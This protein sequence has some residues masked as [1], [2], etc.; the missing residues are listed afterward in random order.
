MVWNPKMKRILGISGLVILFMISI[1]FSSKKQNN[2]SINEVVVK[3][4]NQ[5]DNYFID[6]LEIVSLLNADNTDYVLGLKLNQLDLK[7]LER[8]VMQHP[9]VRDVEVFRDLKGNLMV[10]VY[11][12]KP[13]ARVINPDGPD[14]YIS[15]EGKILPVSPKFTAR[16]P[17]IKLQNQTVI[18][19]ALTATEDGQKLFELLGFIQKDQFW[20]AQ[21]AQIAVDGDME[22]T[23]YP[24]V[25]K[26]TVEFGAIDDID[27][28][29][30]KLKI[31]YKKILPTKGWNYYET[32]SL[33]YK[34]QIVAK[35]P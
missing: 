27:E 16:V 31:F 35:K 3:I 32:V 8:R 11:Q 9:F 22:V 25:T 15:D 1:G 23:I 4:E 34:D 14:H 26:Q 5:E 24:Q 29:F 19:T 12:T 20:S 18:D 13:I 21:V 30:K 2:R 33:K 17:L 7:E 28:K 6:N 10:E